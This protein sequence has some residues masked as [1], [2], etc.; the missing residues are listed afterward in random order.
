[1]LVAVILAVLLGLGGF[2]A[3]SGFGQGLGEAVNTFVIGTLNIFMTIF[4]VV[5]PAVVFIVPLYILS[6]RDYKYLL[7]GGIYGLA[8]ILIV[9]LFNLPALAIEFYQ[10]TFQASFIPVLGTIAEYLLAFAYW[11]YGVILS[12]FDGT[13][14]EKI[15]QSWAQ[16]HNKA[17]KKLGGKNK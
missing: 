10:N 14:L 17:R 16:A 12:I 3:L 5:W 11:M 15:K 9:Y 2:F 7:L 4:I 13:L 6:K 1:M 8:M